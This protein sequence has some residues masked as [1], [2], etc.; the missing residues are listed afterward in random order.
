VCEN[1]HYVNDKVML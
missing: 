1:Y